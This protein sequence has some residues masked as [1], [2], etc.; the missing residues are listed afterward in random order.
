M[1][2]DKTGVYGQDILDFVPNTGV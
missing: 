2:T 1:S